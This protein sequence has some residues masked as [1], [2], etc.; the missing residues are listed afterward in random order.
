MSLCESHAA[1]KHPHTSTDTTSDA[2]AIVSPPLMLMLQEV[3]GQ[4]LSSFIQALSQ[5]G[6]YGAIPMYACHLDKL[7]RRQALQQLLADNTGTDQL[8]L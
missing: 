7:L 1:A 4:L 5:A 2:E 3:A 6:H 8:G